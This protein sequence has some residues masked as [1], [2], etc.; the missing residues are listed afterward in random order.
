MLVHSCVYSPLDKAHTK[1][2]SI[3]TFFLLFLIP[4]FSL[5]AQDRAKKKERKINLLCSFTNTQT[6]AHASS[7]RIQRADTSCKIMNRDGRRKRKFCEN[8]QI[9]LAFVKFI[10]S[11]HEI[12][13]RLIYLPSAFAR[14]PEFHIFLF[15]PDADCE[16]FALIS[17]LC[18]VFS[19]QLFFP[20]LKINVYTGNEGAQS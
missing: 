20:F 2:S 1:N 10:R 9:F 6:H 3:T 13:N 11:S 7:E 16:T 8:A 15:H 17:I 5:L 12:E 18:S 19:K 14:F 4:R